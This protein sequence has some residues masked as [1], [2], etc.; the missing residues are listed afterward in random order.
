M[1]V[2]AGLFSLSAGLLFG[3]AFAVGFLFGSAIAYVNFHWLE[4][5]V[6]AVAD[7]T[8]GTGRAQS[9]RGVVLRFLMRYVVIAVGA[10]AIFKISPESLYGLLAGLFLPVAAIACEAAWE[11]IVALRRGI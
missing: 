4:Q 5:V 6:S 1:W 10:Y 8:T 2:L 7:K 3:W 9:S 11:V